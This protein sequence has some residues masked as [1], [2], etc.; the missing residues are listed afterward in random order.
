MLNEVQKPFA[1]EM[2]HLAFIH[3]CKVVINFTKVDGTERTLIALPF[4]DIPEEHQ[5]KDFD[6]TVKFDRENP[7][8]TVRIFSEVEQEW[9]SLRVEN[10]NTMKIVL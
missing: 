5:P 3:G 10:I 9:R 4:K 7:P 8:V 6:P 2:I 1:S